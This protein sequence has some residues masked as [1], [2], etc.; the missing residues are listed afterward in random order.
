MT[1]GI[2]FL[3][4]RRLLFPG[5]VK[6]L[7]VILMYSYV[8]SGHSQIFSYPENKILGYARSLMKTLL[9]LSLL[10]IGTSGCSLFK[11]DEAAGEPKLNLQTVHIIL[12]NDAN[13]RSATEIDLVFAYKMDL[14]KSLLKMTAAEY[15]AIADQLRRDYPELLK[16]W[17]WEL[18][19]GQSL[20]NNSLE[21][22][23]AL[24]AIVFARYL[25]PGSHRVRVGSSET[26]HILLKKED[27]CILEQGCPTGSVLPMSSGKRRSAQGEGCSLKS[28]KPGEASGTDRPKGGGA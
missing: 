24:G 19:P 16:I 2:D 9:L 20:N 11:E 18:A 1:R 23:N 3:H 15:F 17:H 10:M 5:G 26:I 27:V 4:N 8:H 21:T 28:K 12:D 6:N 7:F 25:S 14:L 13:N 22:G